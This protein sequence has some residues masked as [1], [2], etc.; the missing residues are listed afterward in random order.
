MAIGNNTQ[1]LLLPLQM[2]RLGICVM[3]VV[4]VGCRGPEK[5]DAPPYDADLSAEA[6][7]QEYDKDDDGELSK[8]ELKAC[9]GILN[10]INRF[11]KN[12]DGQISKEEI[13]D[14]IRIYIADAAGISAINCLVYLDKKPL[15]GAKVELVP[16]PFL[17]DV[18][19]TATGISG[20]NG[21]VALGIPNELLPESMARFRG[22]RLGLYKAKV[23][24]PDVQLPERYVSGEALGAEV[25]P[26]TS[27]IFLMMT[28]K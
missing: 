2:G 14:R 4:A 18:V 26:S 15:T 6:A 10:A 24:H 8:D 3:L 13:A 23:S 25:G 5:V 21:I 12:H 19:E 9:P 28:S 17:G 1:R 11:D 20:R 22:V 7:L 16:E 27:R